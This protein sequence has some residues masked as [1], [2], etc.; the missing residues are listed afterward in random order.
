MYE[1]YIIMQMTVHTTRNSSLIF[2]FM[3]LPG[4]ILVERNG[5]DNLER[6][7]RWGRLP[8]EEGSALN[9]K[10]PTDSHIYTA[11]N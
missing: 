11:L 6:K 2:I 10:N 3:E 4:L 9:N 5:Q 1:S 8:I 7:L